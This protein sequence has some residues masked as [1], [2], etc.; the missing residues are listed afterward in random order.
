MN[1]LEGINGT[2][3][4]SLSGPSAIVIDS[5]PGILYFTDTYN[6]R[7]ISYP[8]GAVVAGGNGQGNSATTLNYPYGL[9]YESVTKSLIIPN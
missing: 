1:L 6:H 2:L 9:T 3:N 8:A 5:S 4:I 7:I